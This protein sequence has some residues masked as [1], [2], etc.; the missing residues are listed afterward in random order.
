ME[1]HIFE[2]KNSKEKKGFT[3]W[4]NFF[5][6]KLNPL[7]KKQCFVMIRG[8][9][10][11]LQNWNSLS[12]SWNLLMIILL[13]QS[14]FRVHFL[15]TLCV[16]IFFWINEKGSKQKPIWWSIFQKGVVVVNSAERNKVLEGL[17]YHTPSHFWRSWGSLWLVA[18]DTRGRSSFQK[19]E[20]SIEGREGVRVYIK[21]ETI[22][23]FFKKP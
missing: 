8:M 13:K 6:Y 18:S 3:Q 1:R 5:F 7:T 20:D 19:K 16:Y 12:C 17:G 22:S 2:L 9:G 4:L 11:R 15:F 14:V 10:M 21:R 23:I